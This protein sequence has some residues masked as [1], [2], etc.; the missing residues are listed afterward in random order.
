M[1]DYHKAIRALHPEVVKV[2][3]TNDS[4]TAY[5]ADNN[6]VAWDKTA[7]DA[8]VDPNAYKYQRA[9]EYPDFK[10]YLDAIVKGDDTQKQAYIDACLAVKAKYPKG[11]V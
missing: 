9:D 2:E 1:V 7:A 3:E 4:I 8:W 11:S 6:I 10:E 5:D